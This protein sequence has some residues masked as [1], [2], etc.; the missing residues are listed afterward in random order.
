MTAR[1]VVNADDFGLTTGTND[2]IIDAHR[3]GI[4]TSASLLA[5]GSAFEQAVE[6]ARQ[7]PSLGVGVHLTLTEGPPVSAP[8]SARP[9]LGPDGQFPLSNQPFV[10]ALIA[11]RLPQDAIRT[12]FAAQV[13][14]IL[15][16]GIKPTHLDG[17]KYIHLL[18]GIT[19]LAIE[20]THRAHI[21][22][23]RVAYPIIDKPRRVARIPGL[24]IIT[25][26]GL[27][28]HNRVR[29]A[30]LKTADRMAGFVDTGHLNEA[31]IRNM[32]RTP[33]EGITEL[34]CHPAYRT[35]QL[36]MLRQ[37]GYSWIGDY[38]FETETKAVSDPALRSEIEALGWQLASFR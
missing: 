29:R 3:Q 7:Y 11:G 13:D 36:E 35:A 8:D 15:A 21:P 1:L 9:L 30:G 18:P 37:Q 23:M 32:M 16:V 10:C 20:V 4:V 34:I 31:A 26:L 12:E 24:A 33:R 14:K 2:A 25:L 6:L 27:L 22:V 17:H 19:A 38:D 5:N 28:A